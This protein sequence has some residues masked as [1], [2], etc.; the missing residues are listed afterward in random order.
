MSPNLERLDAMYPGVLMLDAGQTAA[1]LGWDRKRIYNLAAA[2]K[3]PF[4]R[5]VGDLIVIPKVALAD[6][7]DGTLSLTPTPAPATTPAPRKRGRPR[8][9]LL[10]LAFQQE[11]QLVTERHAYATAIQA[12]AGV[13]LD[14]EDL[15]GQNAW[16]TLQALPTVLARAQTEAVLR[17]LPMPSLAPGAG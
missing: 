15:P 5:R 14:P 6:W 9:A 7:L 1:A 11:L 8:K 17:N 12:C 4:V 10:T 2:E 3:L 16:Q 13:K